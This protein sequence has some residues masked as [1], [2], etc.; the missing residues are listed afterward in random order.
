MRVSS[1]KI[2]WTLQA[3]LVGVVSAS[4]ALVVFAS[5][6]AA[7]VRAGLPVGP[8]VTGL[9]G[10]RP[11]ATR[12]TFPVS[13]QVQASVDVGTGNLEVATIG[14]SLPSVNSSAPIGVTFN[15]RATNTGMVGDQTANGWS[16]SY[17][18]AGYLSMVSGGVVYVGADGSTWLFTPVSGSSTMFTSPAGMKAVLVATVSGATVTGYTLTDL[19]ARTVVQFD[20]DGQPD[21]IAD[22]NGNQ[23]AITYSY[24]KPLTMVAT[25]GATADRTA[26]FSYVPATYTMTVTQTSGTLTRNVK[27]VK[28]ASSDLTSIVDAEGHTTTFGYSSGN[29]TSIT[30]VTGAV[31]NFTFDSSHRVT[32]VDQLNTS[33]GSPGTSTTRLTYPLSTQTLVAGPDTSTGTPVG[34]GPHTTYTIDTTNRVT[35]VTDAAGRVRSATYTPNLDVAS[36][37]VGS[38]TGS[39]T[40]TGTYGANSGQSLTAVKADGGATDTAA[41]AN[42]SAATKYLPSSSAD[43]ASNATTFTYNG[44]GNPLTSSNTALAATATL[45]VNPADGTVTSATAPG[46]GTN[47]T[48]YGYNSTHQLSTITPPTGTSLGTRTITYDGFGRVATETDGKGV[49]LTFGY[50]K[51]DRL[52]STTYSGTTHSVVNTYDNAGHLA[53]SVDGSGTTTNTYDQLGRLTSTV[54]TAGGGTEAYGYDK[55]S[56][57][58]TTTD[59]RGTTTDTF[60]ASGVATSMSYVKSGTAHLTNFATDAQGRRTDEWLQS[61]TG[62]TVWAGHVHT[63]YDTSGRISELV[64]QTGPGTS[65]YTTVMD[66]SYCYNTASAAPTC[67][68]GSTTDRSKLQWSLDNLTGQVTT[69]TYDAGGRLKTMAQSSGTAP[70]NTYNYTYD[71]N[72]NRLTAVV[73]GANP[74]SQTLTYNAAN[75][76]TTTGYTYDGAGNLTANPAGTYS[77]NGAEQMI[78][79]VVGPTTTTYTYAGT[80]QTK[81][82]SESTTS[83]NTY[84][85][86]YGRTDQQGNA[87]VEQYHVGLTAYVE[88]D[89]LTGAPLMLRTSSG[90]EALYVNDGIDNPVGLLT[91][92]NTNAFTL[93]Y[94]PYGAANL[95]AGGTGNGYYENPYLFKGGIQDRATGY[96]K[97]GVRWYN[98]LT[99]SWTQEDAI[100]TPLDPANANRY[101]YAGD[102]PINNLDPDGRLSA[103]TVLKLIEA[104]ITGRNIANLI[105]PSS[106]TVGLEAAF[107]VGCS[108]LAGAIAASTLGG[109]IVAIGG[110]LILELMFDSD[111]EEG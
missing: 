111:L 77:Y 21:F 4:L 104:L 71:A 12:L 96:V 72:G 6:A 27:Y 66:V 99:G 100:D 95:T 76:I 103:I 60:D 14:F 73:T 50:D 5:P 18:A 44:A 30:S 62:N 35:S 63:S 26:N 13:D 3:V 54:N 58:L 84:N 23:T 31:T 78:Q 87:I 2:A 47:S 52:L 22:R 25:A 68:T 74:S 16:Y 49:T 94:D 61:N 108:I 64:A 86:T 102:D 82:L 107:G 67:G 33:T 75:Q 90:I 45:T 80:G 19:T 38:G 29:L 20:A 48:V 40:T 88:S 10:N 89:P 46:N 92:F 79:A 105:G 32:Q 36:S 57:L 34:T 11:S 85:L 98:P 109:G 56:N 106:N 93:T 28:N 15:S 7:A 97:F 9:T 110:C 55:A 37:T 51:I 53:T 41:Y 81:V 43:D 8:T 24:T 83:G 39:G 101:A 59:T 91:D 42:T 70:N 17:D 69:F 65:S 1:V